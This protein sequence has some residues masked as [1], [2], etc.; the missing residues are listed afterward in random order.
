MLLLRDKDACP[1]PLHGQV[2]ASS[3]K[4][5]RHGILLYISNEGVRSEIVEPTWMEIR[6]L[7]ICRNKLA[8][9]LSIASQVASRPYPNMLRHSDCERC[10]SAAEC[11]LNHAALESGSKS[12]SGVPVLFS[13]V[14]RCLLPV[15]L[16]YF[17]TWNMLIDLEAVAYASSAPLLW[18]ASGESLEEMAEK[19]ISGLYIMACSVVESYSIVTLKKINQLKSSYATDDPISSVVT[20]GDRVNISVENLQHRGVE[21]I[22]DIGSRGQFNL[23][24]IEPVV[25]TG[26]VLSISA[27]EIQVQVK[28]FPRRIN[29]YIGQSTTDV[30]FRIDKDDSTVGVGTM[31]SNLLKLFIDSFDPNVF[32]EFKST[33]EKEA[34]NSPD[35]QSLL[36]ALPPPGNVK[37]RRLIVDLETPTFSS[38]EVPATTVA[39]YKGCSKDE[40]S[41]SFSSLNPQQRYAVTR[42]FSAR[43]YV[44]LLGMPGTGKS[45]TLSHAI[46]SLVAKGFRVLVTSYTHSAVDTLVTKLKD[47]GMVNNSILT[48]TAYCYIFNEN[49]L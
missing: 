45:S 41:L 3:S 2:G 16:K 37:I 20:K 13:Y 43:D 17:Q 49:P 15:H 7:V 10:Y 27:L 6:N 19:C 21:D 30:S 47:A 11:M 39:T 14:T 40:L 29:R 48:I 24:D 23:N 35:G 1:F 5:V 33:V 38:A 12:S 4:P 31:R 42:I 44:L 8:I 46:R 9:N 26:Y 28:K 22:E 18:T 34:S 36:K 32:R 25:C